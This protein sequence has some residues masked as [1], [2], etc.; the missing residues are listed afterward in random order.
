M[1]IPVSSRVVAYPIPTKCPDCKRNS[2]VVI[3]NEHGR[4]YTCWNKHCGFVGVE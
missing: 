1:S 2:L 3:E 4:Y